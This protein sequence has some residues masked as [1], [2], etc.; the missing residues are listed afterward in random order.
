MKIISHRGIWKTV[1]EQNRINSLINSLKKGYGVEF[2]IRDYNLEI[3]ISHDLPNKNSE[4]LENFFKK[5]SDNKNYLFINIKSDGLQVKLKKLLKKYKIKKYFVFDMSLPDTLTY[6]KLNINYSIRI[7]NIEKDFFLYDK[8]K[9]IW[10]DQF[11]KDWINKNE[12]FYHARNKKNVCIVSSE[13]HQKNKK[14][15]NYNQWKKFKN[16][17]EQVLKKYKNF[18]LMICTD[19]PEIADS[20]FN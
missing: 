14:K 15:I 6:K 9:S 2:D 18:K 13:L 5:I 7:S 17:E 8:A 3:V 19:F 1:N 16:I 4:N 10:L 11:N 12:I 20:Y